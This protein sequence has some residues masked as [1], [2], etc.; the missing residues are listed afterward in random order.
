MLNHT[1]RRM[2]LVF[3]AMLMAVHLL[4]GERQAAADSTADFFVSPR[5]NDAW[6]GH[7][8]DPGEKDG[9]FKTIA[10]ARDAVRA[11]G[12]LRSKDRTRSVLIV[13]RGGTYY[14]DEPLEFGP[15]DSGTEEA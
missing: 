7:L 14:L 15:E 3:T 6:S 11:L 10:R 9:P 4:G 1:T 2:G 8:P 12:L 5:G 13:L